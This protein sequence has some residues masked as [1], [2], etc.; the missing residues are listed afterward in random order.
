MIFFPA[1]IRNKCYIIIRI[2]SMGMMVIKKCFTNLEKGVEL[3]N[4]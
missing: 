4:S 1:S 2:I 3:G